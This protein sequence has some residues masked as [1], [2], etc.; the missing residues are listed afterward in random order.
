MKT[1]DIRNN[2][3]SVNIGNNDNLEIELGKN[4][5]HVHPYDM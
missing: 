5:N 2:R 4:D 1:N 3:I